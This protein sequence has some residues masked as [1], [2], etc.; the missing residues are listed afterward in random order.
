MG[1]CGCRLV[2]D[3]GSFDHAARRSFPTIVGALGH[4]VGIGRL[5][6]SPRP[7][8]QYRAPDV[9]AGPV[10]AVNGAFMLMRR[11]ALDDVGLFDEG[12]WMYME[13]LDLCYRFRQAGWLTWYEPSVTVAHA[14]AGSSGPVRSPRLNYAFHYGM[15]RFYRKH[16]AATTNPVLNALVY[17]GIFGKLSVSLLRNAVRVRWGVGSVPPGPVSRQLMRRA[18]RTRAGYRLK[19][20]VPRRVRVAHS[21]RH[22]AA[23]GSPTRH[24]GRPVRRVMLVSHGDLT[25]NSGRHAHA[26]ARELSCLDYAVAVAVPGTSFGLQD[27][28][29]TSFPVLSHRDAAAGRLPFT[30]DLSNT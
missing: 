7:L 13:D 28:G 14:K 12:Y 10:D 15:Y 20:A 11:S 3:D 4:F 23:V 2:R 27:V 16:Y 24:V 22:G 21:R 8:A 1:I 17:G 25:T 30:P 6:R 19:R 26:I 29:P 9:V 5:A 18:G